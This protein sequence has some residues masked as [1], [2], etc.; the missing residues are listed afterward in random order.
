MLSP[1]KMWK[2]RHR[3]QDGLEIIEKNLI[4]LYA[5]C[6]YPRQL[7]IACEA[8]NRTAKGWN[9]DSDEKEAIEEAYSQESREAMIRYLAFML[10]IIL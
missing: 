6:G 3:N 4:N 7:K 10:W 1:T 8:V 2:E 5:G 9:L